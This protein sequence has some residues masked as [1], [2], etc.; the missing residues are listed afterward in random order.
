ME[1]LLDSIRVP[2]PHAAH[3]CEIKPTY[4]D[5]EAHALACV[6]KP[7]CGCPGEACGFVGSMAALQLDH[8]V[9]CA[10]PP[11]LP[12]S[13]QCAPANKR[14]SGKREVT[15]EDTD[16]FDCGIC[17]LPLKPPIFQCEV[18]HVVCLPCRKKLKNPA[19]CHVCG[20]RTGGFRRC[21]AMERV[22]ES[23]HIPCPNS[24]SGCTAKPAYHEQQSH[25]K[26]CTMLSRFH[27][28][29]EACN[30]VGS[31]DALLAHIAGLDGWP[32]T[33]RVRESKH[34]SCKILLRNGFNFLR[35]NIP[36]ATA[37]APTHVL[38]LLNLVRQQDGAVAISALCVQSQDGS[39]KE[40]ICDFRYYSF[41]NKGGPRKDDRL[42]DFC[43][44]AKIKVACTDFSKGSPNLDD[45]LRRFLFLLNLAWQPDGATATSVFCIQSQGSSGCSCYYSTRVGKT[46]R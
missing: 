43:Q 44:R 19:K 24:A 1:Q 12:K 32:C 33:T 5:R 16:A 7:T 18:G 41:H 2:C 38:F 25:Q 9:V 26:S 14:A 37:T 4:H 40:L 30:F 31:M 46:P 13:E 17:F 22:V 39:L 34:E 23:I 20:G 11:K 15:L 27:C 28:P 3:G 29:G 35:T 10:C 21:H 45:C 6:H 8:I 42:I 36:N